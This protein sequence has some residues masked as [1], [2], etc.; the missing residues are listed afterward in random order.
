MSSL[1]RYDPPRLPHPTL[2]QSQWDLS[3][4]TGYVNIIMPYWTNIF[5]MTSM[6]SWMTVLP[7][8]QKSVTVMSTLKKSL[9]LT[10]CVIASRIPYFS[11]SEYR[12][13]S[14]HFQ[15]PVKSELIE[16]LSAF[17]SVVKTTPYLGLG[18]GE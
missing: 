5:E 3:L 7:V 14:Y 9:A 10:Y 13:L 12:T 1:Y 18:R 15:F 16:Y 8:Y 11:D 2:Y 4:S 6:C 17:K